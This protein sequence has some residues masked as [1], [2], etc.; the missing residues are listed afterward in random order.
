MLGFFPIFHF[1]VIP[2]VVLSGFV[3]EISKIRIILNPK[4][5]TPQPLMFKICFFVLFLIDYPINRRFAFLLRFTINDGVFTLCPV[6]LAAL[7]DYTCC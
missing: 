4:P 7:V 1:S 3:Q 2:S 6:S 5:F